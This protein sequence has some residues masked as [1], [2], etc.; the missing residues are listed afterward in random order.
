M[1]KLFSGRVQPSGVTALTSDKSD[2]IGV[3]NISL[4]DRYLSEPSPKSIRAFNFLVHYPLTTLGE[5]QKERLRDTVTYEICETRG[6]RHKSRSNAPLVHTLTSH[7]PFFLQQQHLLLHLEVT[8][9]DSFISQLG[10]D[11]SNPSFHSYFVM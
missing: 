2:V 10:E 11:P 4:S 1:S 9:W 6:K 3:Q 8:L 5:R 7:L